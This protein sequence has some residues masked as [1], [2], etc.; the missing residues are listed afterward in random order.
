M[1]AYEERGQIEVKLRA[2]AEKYFKSW[3]L[4]DF[5]SAF[6][7]YYI[8]GSY[9]RIPQL[10][11]MFRLFRLFRLVRMLTITRILNRCVEDLALL[12]RPLDLADNSSLDSNTDWTT[13]SCCVPP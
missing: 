13:R 11:R 10:A 1:S 2:I 5:I 7:L 9:F 12:A 4:L 8:Q 3:F 6:P